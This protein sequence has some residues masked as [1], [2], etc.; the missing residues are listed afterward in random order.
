MGFMENIK[1]DS[2]SLAIS[3]AAELIAK[4]VQEDPEKNFDT[5]MKNLASLDSMFGGSG[6]FKTVIE[7]IYEHPGTRKW[8]IRLMTRDTE[9]VGTFV[10][11]FFGNCSLKWLEKSKAMEQ[12]DGLCPPF[13]IL[14]SPSMRCNLHCKG[15]YA[16][17]YSSKDDMDL[18][19]F[20][21]IITEGK[22]LGVYFYTILGGEPFIKFNDIYRMAKK[23][24]DCLI[25]IF[26]NGTLITE[27]I[28]D[29]ILDA[30]NIVVAFSV[31]STKE[32][33]GF[34]R[35]PGVYD[36]V[37]KSID[38]MRRRNLMYG[39]SL[40]L[41]SKNYKTFMSKKFLKFWENQG[42][43]FGWNFLFM[44]VGKNA[45]LS[46]MP[47]PEQR[48]T[49]GEF[50]KKYRE[51]EP[52]YI[53]DF[54]AD[55]PA[56][57]GC[58]AGGRRYLHI[59]NRGDIEPCIFA[60]FS[61]HNIKECHLIDA[62]KSPF[63]T[64]IRMQQP[65]TDNLLRPCMIIDNP[66]V[67]R[68]ACRIC[69]A[70]PTEEGAEQLI[71]DPRIMQ[72]LDEYSASVAKIADPIWEKTYR[73]KIDNMYERKRSYGEGIDRIEYKLNRKKFLENAK[74]FAEKD[75]EYAKNML[76]AAE[77]AY[78]NYGIDTRRQITLIKEKKAKTEIK[79]HIE[80]TAY[81]STP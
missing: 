60:H 25:Q 58:I 42:I 71:K 53:M 64:H 27:K 5:M 37:L 79:E 80:D 28:A 10:K 56:V 49:F 16:S 77:Y 26:T 55:A 33:T 15:C 24:N 70:K 69:N 31:N 41:T 2:E 21:R 67:L 63:F 74:R 45:D 7:W 72:A 1:T 44:P 78:K 19:T 32:D 40:V 76:A 14:I 38:M 22:E 54:W 11:N 4:Y 3:K 43:V 73:Y 30:K 51:E 39:M 29:Q 35:G 13:N 59:N 66:Q 57:N 48:L 17:S 47:T 52:L 68:D 61:T 18:E 36:R 50:I 65:H 12:E 23:H 9:Q 20:D 81:D 6:Q 75:P 62:L 34:I 8:F 46:L